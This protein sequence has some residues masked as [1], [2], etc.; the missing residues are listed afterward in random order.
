MKKCK[1]TL[2]LIIIFILVITIKV[3]ANTT[4]EITINTDKTSVAV[5]DTVEITIS[6]K[7]A[8]GIEGIDSTLKYDETKLKLINEEELATTD[9]T[10]VSGK[11]EATGEFKLSILYTGTEEV[12]IDAEFAKLN[13]EVL[14]KANE[15]ETLSVELAQIEIGDSN[16]GWS[17]LEDEEITFAVEKG[18]V[19]NGT[20]LVK[21]VV[22]ATFAIVLVVI[23]SKKHKGKV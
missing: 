15:S 18:Q 6:A 3:Y 4:S 14:K 7:C 9:F 10:S 20:G 17:E 16:G 2:L 1:K 12:P 13:F 22:I 19:D 5:G 11:D 23:I 8:N 21:Y